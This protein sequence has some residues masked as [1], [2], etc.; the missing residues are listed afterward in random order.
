M[1]VGLHKFNEGTPI[2]DNKLVYLPL[3]SSQNAVM[4]NA[5]VFEI[6]FSH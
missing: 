2:L 5:Y 4:F 6:A 3:S 1:L